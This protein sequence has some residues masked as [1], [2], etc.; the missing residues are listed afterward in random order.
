MANTETE[1]RIVK[2]LRD[3]LTLYPILGSGKVERLPSTPETTE[4]L[5]RLTL[6]GEVRNGYTAKECLVFLAGVWFAMGRSK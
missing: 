1:T 5:Y 4:T 3:L 2:A 6:S